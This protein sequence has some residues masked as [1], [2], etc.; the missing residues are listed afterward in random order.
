MYENVTVV[1]SWLFCAAGE[2]LVSLVY[3]PQL[4]GN[5]L[6]TPPS[7]PWCRTSLTPRSPLGGLLLTA[8]VLYPSKAMSWREGK[9]APLPGKGATLENSLLQ[10]RSQSATSLKKLA[11]NSGFL[12]LMTL[13]RVLTWRFLEASFL[14]SVCLFCEFL[15]LCPFFMD[16]LLL[17]FRAH[18]RPEERSGGQLC[19]FRAGVLSVRGTVRCLLGLLVFKWTPPA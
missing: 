17:F 13:G 14:V 9:L 4:H 15:L 11:T 3:P 10:L 8:T 18:C 5:I 6:L 16:L 12:L 7:M 19:S 1:S 2:P